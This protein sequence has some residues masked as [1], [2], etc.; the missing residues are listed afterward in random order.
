MTERKRGRGEQVVTGKK[1]STSFSDHYA[2]TIQRRD[3]IL[4]RG[5]EKTRW[6][7]DE[8][9]FILVAHSPKGGKCIVNEGD[10][11]K[12]KERRRLFTLF[13]RCRNE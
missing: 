6:D 13:E 4:V 9:D 5:T 12:N 10:M 1:L 7:I 11:V 8:G 3:G 2:G